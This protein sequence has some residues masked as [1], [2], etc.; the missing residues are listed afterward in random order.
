ML[1]RVH[2]G[3]LAAL[4]VIM[5]ATFGLVSAPAATAADTIVPVNFVSTPRRT[6]SA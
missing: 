6:S 4:M 2:R 3:G 5:L 1:T